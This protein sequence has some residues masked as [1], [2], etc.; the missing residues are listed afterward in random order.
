MTRNLVGDRFDTQAGKIIADAELD[1]MRGSVIANLSDE[2]A[3]AL[4]DAHV[5]G[6]ELGQYEA[7]FPLLDAPGMPE[8]LNK[9]ISAAIAAI[10]T[11]AG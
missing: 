3:S 9:Q 5:S 6:R 7:L 11:K 10:R 4:R 8:R 2:I 1:E